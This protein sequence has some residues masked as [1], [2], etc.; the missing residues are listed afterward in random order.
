MKSIKKIE[1]MSLDELLEASSDVNVNVPD[2]FMGRIGETVE[3][4]RTVGA[5]TDDD[6]SYETPYIKRFIP[7]ISA[8]AAIALIAGI[9]FS[10]MDNE[11]KDTF[12]DPRL[13]YA[14]LEKAFGRISDGINR[15]VAMAEESERIIKKT[16]AV[17]E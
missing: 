14:E 12:D 6:V 15:G 9:G 4:A 5:L 13:A 16:T 8:A 10:L 1:K 7:F 3:T 17:Y 2:G 11:P